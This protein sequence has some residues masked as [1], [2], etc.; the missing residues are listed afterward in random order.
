M[1]T[2]PVLFQWPHEVGPMITYMGYCGKGGLK[3]CSEVDST[4]VKWFKIDEAGTSSDGKWWVEELSKSATRSSHYKALTR[5]QVSYQK[6]RVTIPKDLAPG[7][8]LIRHE[9]IALHLATEYY[10]AEFYAGC[11]Q[12]K[13]GGSGIKVPADQDLLSFPGSYKDN[14]KGIYTP[15][16]FNPGNKY[17]FPGG[18]VAK[19]V[20]GGGNSGSNDGSND[21]DDP[22][23]PETGIHVGT[24][25]CRLTK[26]SAIT[27]RGSYYPRHHSR[28]MRDVLS[29]HH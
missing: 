16:V 18:P 26:K 19:L 13:V 14:D 4:T 28:V 23:V 1:I 11:A 27:K 8:Y 9:L 20:G 2:D 24:G 29:S 3:D 10:G 12:L 5:L 22:S 21:N 25:S 17:Q 7:N 6:A 15:N